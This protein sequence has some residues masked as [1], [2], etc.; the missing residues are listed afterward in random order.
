MD[1]SHVQRDRNPISF[2]DFEV[3]GLHERIAATNCRKDVLYKTPGLWDYEV[4]VASKC[5]KEVKLKRKSFARG[6]YYGPTV[7]QAHSV[8]SASAVEKVPV[9]AT[10][11]SM[12]IFAVLPS[13]QSGLQIQSQPTPLH[14]VMKSLWPYFSMPSDDEDVDLPYWDNRDLRSSREHP[15]RSLLQYYNIVAIDDERDRRQ[16]I[17]KFAR[18]VSDEDGYI[19]VPE[20]WALTINM[21]EDLKLP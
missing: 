5:I 9:H 1:S 4:A 15:I 20:I 16:V 7:H 19:Y 2:E 10:F 3:S 17:T 21:C 13:Y 6:R 12:P 18:D 11:L 14:Q 8:L